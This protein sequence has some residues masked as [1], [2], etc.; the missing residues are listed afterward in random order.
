MYEVPDQKVIEKQRAERKEKKNKK[1]KRA[2]AKATEA[3]EGQVYDIG[4]KIQKEFNGK[5]FS[6]E[7]IKYDKKEALYKILY[8][9]GDVEEFDNEDMQK[10]FCGRKK[11]KAVD[12]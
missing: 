3:S 4:S 12:T 10:Y 8:D 5:L 6:G 11:R 7:V 2:I 1:K 9:D